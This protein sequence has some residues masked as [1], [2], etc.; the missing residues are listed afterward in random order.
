MSWS[1]GTFSRT[2]GI[3]TGAGIW[4]AAKAA[5]RKI[6]A[7]EHDTHDQDLATGINSCLHKGGQN[8][9]TANLNLG[10]FRFT[11][12]GAASGRSDLAPVSG[13]Q[14][15]TYVWAGSTSGGT[16]TYTATLTPAITAYAAGLAVRVLV[17]LANTGAMTLNLNGLGAKSV[18]WRDQE[19]M[20]GEFVGLVELIYDGTDF[21]IVRPGESITDT[22]SAAGTTQGT[23]TALVSTINRVTSATAASAEGVRLPTPRKNGRIIVVNASSDTIKIYPTS[24]HQIK[25]LGANVAATMAAQRAVEFI[26]T[27]TTQWEAIFSTS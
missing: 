5:A 22:I 12:A 10:G 17:N 2:N 23:A 25:N 18:K 19:L 20:A 14:D 15:G 26:G 1:G 13:V 7:S 11:N 9:A 16:T 6:L 21:Q 4:A 3:D 8:A 27:S 24:G